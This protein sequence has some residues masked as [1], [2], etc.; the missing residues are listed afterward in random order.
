MRFSELREWLAA[1]GTIPRTPS[2]VNVTPASVAMAEEPA[3]RS[4]RIT[5]A[6]ESLTIDAHCDNAVLESR[7][8]FYYS[9]SVDGTEVAVL[10]RH[11][12]R[13][14]R[15]GEPLSIGNSISIRKPARAS[16]T[17]QITG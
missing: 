17:I 12:Y 2:I 1:I 13:S 15:V 8:E 14:L 3:G 16:A 6:F 5:I 11:L 4:Q 10:P 9:F 7:G